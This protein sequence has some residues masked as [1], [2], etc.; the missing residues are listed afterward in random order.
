MAT[1]RGSLAL[2]IQIKDPKYAGVSLQRHN[3]RGGWVRSRVVVLWIRFHFIRI[4]IRIQSG[5]RALMTKN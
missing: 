2:Y 4:R 1:N 5:S 3:I